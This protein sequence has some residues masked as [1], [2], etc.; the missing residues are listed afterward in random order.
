MLIGGGYGGLKVE[1]SLKGIIQGVH[2]ANQKIR[3]L[4]LNTTPQ[5]GNIEFVELFEDSAVGALYSLGRI[6]KQETRSFRI[7]MEEKKL[8]ILLGSKKR[9]PNEISTDW[10]NRICL[11]YTSPSPRDRTRYRMP[12]SA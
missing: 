7:L 8:H 9:I 2:N 3:N 10:W 11:L 5:I 4:K 12:S 1:N 6:E